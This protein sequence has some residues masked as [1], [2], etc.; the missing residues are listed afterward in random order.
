MTSQ[1]DKNFEFL[2]EIAFDVYISI[3]NSSCDSKAKS[4]IFLILIKLLSN[5]L[6]AENKGEDSEKYRRI[7]VTNP[8]ISLLFNI[9]HIYDFLKIIGFEEQFQNENLTLYLPKENL[10]I[11]LLQKIIPYLNLLSLNH[12]EE[13]CSFENN[14]IN[15]NEDNE[16]KIIDNSNKIIENKPIENKKKEDKISVLDILKNTKNVR[17][18]I[19]N[20]LPEDWNTH[21]NEPDEN[22][23]TTDWN[24][25][26]PHQNKEGLNFLKQ[27]GP[28]RFHNALAYKK[29]KQNS[30][31]FNQLLKKKNNLY[32]SIDDHFNV[33]NDLRFENKKEMT[34]SDLEFKN[35]QNLNKCNDIIGK[36]CLIL[37]NKFRQKNNLPKLEWDD[38]IWRVAYT[39]SKNMGLKIVP[40]GHKGFNERIRKFPF[41]FYSA[42]EN[43]FMCNGYSQYNISELGV[44]GWI[45]S[46][47]H[48]KNLLSNSTHCAIATYKTESGEFY[49]TQ[50]FARK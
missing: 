49:L 14:N 2:Y 19:S 45:N 26:A 7:K 24:N 5:I 10:N 46:P 40:F 20:T 1:S 37:T 27:T 21:K 42:A 13:Q 17:L 15:N 23:N 8:N 34:L 41:R 31:Y 30:S 9:D 6:N 25:I 29:E 47:G 32:H 38:G 18:G 43:V 16:S 12:Q 28:E 48:R 39:H 36:Q 50:M 22:T 3:I 4:K 33:I 35:P 44:K 11:T